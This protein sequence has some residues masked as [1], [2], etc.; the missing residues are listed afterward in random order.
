MVRVMWVGD[1]GED[2]EA[3]I[4]EAAPLTATEEGI[5]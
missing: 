3:S 1:E 4:R 2:R 5:A